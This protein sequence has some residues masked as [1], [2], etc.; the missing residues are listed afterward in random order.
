MLS[1]L[2]WYAQHVRRL[3]CEDIAISAQEVDELAFLFGRELG[4]NPH[5]LGRVGGVDPH[6]LGF[7]EQMEVRRRSWFVAVWDC[8]DRQ[9][10]KPRELRRVDDRSGKLIVLMVAHEGMQEGTTY[11]DGAARSWHLQLEVGVV[12]DCHEFGIAWPPQDGMVGP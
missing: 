4:P 12:G 9:F 10:P 3:P 1:D 2:L 8:W 7:L 6:R 11:G 5:R